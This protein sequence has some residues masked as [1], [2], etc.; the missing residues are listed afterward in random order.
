MTAETRI[1]CLSQCNSKF[2]AHKAVYIL[3]RKEAFA[4][5]IVPC[6]LIKAG[7]SFCNCSGVETRTPLSRATIFATPGTKNSHQPNSVTNVHL[8]TP[9]MVQYK[10]CTQNE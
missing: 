10:T 8:V 3:T 9:R 6:G 7:L 1:F 4:A 2:T 5:V